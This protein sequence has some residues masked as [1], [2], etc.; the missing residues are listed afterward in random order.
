M[1]TIKEADRHATD[2]SLTMLSATDDHAK[3]VDL[4][5]E[6]VRELRFFQEHP[7]LEQQLVGQWVALDGDELVSHGTDLI[8]VVRRAADMGHPNP[9]ITRV[10][11][12]A[13]TYVF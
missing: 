10:L 3:A 2:D 5:V 9:F 11:D 12:P 13:V 4:Q 1:K 6:R 7:E 8:E